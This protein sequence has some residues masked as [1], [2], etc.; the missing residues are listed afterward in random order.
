MPVFGLV[1]CN[2]FF[3]SCER[4]IDPSLNGKPVI[5][6]SNNDGVVVA[7]SNEAKAL[8]ISW[9]PFYKIQGLI[10]AY[11][12]K[13]FSSNYA[14]YKEISGRVMTTLSEFTPRI[15]HYSIDEAFLHLD[16]IP[17]R[18]QYGREIR[19][20]VLQWTGI[21]VS[22]G[23]ARTRTLAKVANRLAK[24]SKK[25]QGV[26]DLTDSPYLEVALE[27][28]PV[29]ELWGIGRRWGEKMQQSGIQSA[30]QLR[31][32]DDAFLMKRFNNV[33][34]MR[35]VYEL[36]GISCVADIAPVVSK[37]IMSSLT[38]GRY[39]ETL[40]E[41]RQAIA[42]HCSQAAQKMRS[43]GL[44]ARG[45]YV[46]LKTNKYRELGP[47]YSN[48]YKI[49]L[50][51]ATDNTS[52]LIAWATEALDVIFRDGYL[53]NKAGAMMYDLVPASELQI[54]LLDPYDRPRI[55]HLMTA[56]DS[57]NGRYG[58]G[59][60]RYGTEGFN[61]NWKMQQQYL[62]DNGKG[63]GSLSSFQTMKPVCELGMSL[64]VIKTL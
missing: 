25:A 31:N 61:K 59:T 19:Q 43:E 63:A 38:F 18:D 40:S 44:A 3:C 58:P 34:L 57:L 13:F 36:R 50:P 17:N 42:M 22:V 9:D 1:D 21:P 41:L 10:K 6:L 12:V 64:P 62:S 24:K 20:R 47:Q 49:G 35:T 2:S 30:L 54:S 39:V 15:E 33:V 37:T 8:G 28:T 23:I 48:G 45:V 52:E 26:L 56:L 11:D 5:V 4:L 51:F 14:L 55:E 46:F 60:L 7:R 27:R 29:E 32:A 16:G 53:Y